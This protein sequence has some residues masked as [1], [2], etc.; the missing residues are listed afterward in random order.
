MIFLA[1]C[2]DRIGIIAQISSFFATHEVNILQLEEHTERG[3]FFIRI[4]GQGAEDITCADWQKI[5]TP[6]GTELDMNFQFFDP[7]EKI[8][9]LLFCSK[10]LH[11]PLEIISRQYSEALNTNILGVVS[12]HEKIKKVSEMFNIPL[13]ITSTEKDSEHEVQQLELIRHY[14]P[15]LIILARY[16]KVLS[17]DFL[18][19]IT[20]P[21]INI[22][23]S[24]LPSFIGSDPYT[25]AYNR[26]VKL[27]GATAHFVTKDL[28]EGPIIIQEV[29]AVTHQYSVSEF[30]HTGAD[31]EKQVL[32]KAVQKFSEHKVIEWEGRTVVFH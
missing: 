15:D 21:I 23:H 16:M 31:I 6:L 20:C 1:H 32:A 28:D 3:R 25:Q 18:R 10:T 19:Q 4:E 11:C 5:F 12:N 8:K 9:V 7:K 30:K 14:N 24:F 13:H 22:H 2:P 17:D 27:I 26:G 29:S